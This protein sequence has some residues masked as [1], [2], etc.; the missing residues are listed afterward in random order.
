MPLPPLHGVGQADECSCPRC[1]DEQTPAW[2]QRLL[3]PPPEAAEADGT[4]SSAQ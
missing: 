4:P 2:I 3:A 1:Q